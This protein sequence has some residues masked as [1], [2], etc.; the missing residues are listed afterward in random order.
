MNVIKNSNELN[1]IIE[2]LKIRNFDE[3]LKKLKKVTIAN[4][5]KSL[6]LKLFAS[7]YSQ[8]KE[9][10]NSIKYYEQI[11]PIERDKFRIHNSIGVA[12]FNLGKINE[13][14]VAYKKATK[15]NLNCD[16]AYNNLG[17]SYSELGDYEEAAKYFAHASNLNDNN[18][19]A[20]NNL[21]NIFLVTKPEN[22][23]GHFLIKINNRIKSINHKITINDSIKLENIK[24]ILDESDNIINNSL[25]KINFNETQIYR[26]NSTNLNCKR[27]FEVFNEF[28]IIPKYCF[29]CYKIQ[30]NLRNVVELIRLF[31]V[32]DNLSLEKNNIRKCVVEIRQ[33]VP[34]NYKG[35]IYCEGID[36]AKKIFNKV[37]AIIDK[38]KFDSVEITIKHGCSEFYESH[39]GYKDINFMGSQP[40]TYDKNWEK[41]ESVFDGRTPS[42][43]ELDKKQIHKSLAG[44]N[45][46]DILIIR[47]WIS[48]ADIIGDFSYKTIYNKKIKS[49]FIYNIL[50]DQLD[51]R[52]KFFK[53]KND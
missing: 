18:D 4:S 21:I 41:N 47:N 29:S 9:W 48:Y 15:E 19:S 14:I 45:L 25:K 8:K 38:I 39:P 23:N 44:I 43:S 32:F 40:M 12:L 30:I 26:K 17:I 5:N 28:N 52:K 46:S 24:N 2:D 7:I 27:H 10:G 1:K 42:R 50:K 53:V 11:L 16:F 36:E 35:Y 13:S 37:S 34:C 6:I 51:F 33:N 31:F 49:N 20:K 3:A 22:V